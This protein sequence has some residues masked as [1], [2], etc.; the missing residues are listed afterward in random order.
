MLRT[1]TVIQILS[2]DL[3]RIIFG[4]LRYSK[5]GFGRI[6]IRDI[7]GTTL[8]VGDR[9][10]PS[11]SLPDVGRF[12]TT[13]TPFECMFWCIQRNDRLTH[14]S[15]LFSVPGV[16]TDLYGIDTLHG[17]HL[18]G[19]AA[20]VAYVFYFVVLSRIFN[21]DIP[22]LNADDIFRLGVLRL[23]SELWNYYKMRQDRDPDFRTKGSKVQGV[24]ENM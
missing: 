11:Q 22:W 1:L 2:S 10:E 18:G 17:W 8:K 12:E 13:D 19:I 5:K 16:A 23:R 24:C 7:P 9:L 15:P 6:L 4:A 3:Q 14:P 21:P 20:F